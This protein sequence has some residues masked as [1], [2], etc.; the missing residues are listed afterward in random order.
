MALPV[1]L[2][3]HHPLQRWLA[4]AV[5]ALLCA[6]LGILL[7]S[8]APWLGFVRTL[9]NVFYDSLYRLR[10]AQNMA[11][12][13][14]VIVAVDDKSIDAVDKDRKIGWPWPRKY[15]GEMVSYL[16]AA[17]AKVIAI[18]LLFD[19][20]SVYNNATNHDDRDFAEA[21]DA[22]AATTPTVLA[23]YLW[24]DGT[25][26]QPVPPV[27]KKITGMATISEE[28][29]IRSYQ[30][31]VHGRASLALE[32]M[33][34]LGAPVPEW[35]SSQTPFLLRYY[36]PHAKGDQPATFKYVRAAN[37]L[38]AAEGSENAGISPEMF[39]GK[40][41]FIATIT[42]GTF[43]L[44]ASPLSP[45]FPGVEVHATAAAN[46]LMNQRVTPV[47]AGMR[48]LLLIF[49]CFTAAAGM[50]VP[51]RIPFKVLGGLSGIIIVL[52]AT[53]ALFLSPD[54]RWLPPAAAL[55]AATASAFTALIWT[56][57]TELRQR[58][59]L[60]K[61]ISHYVSKSVADE[62][63]RDPR[64][65]SLSGERREM[66]VMFTDLVNFTTLSEKLDEHRLPDMLNFY[67]QEMSGVIL[68]QNGTLDKYI[69]DSIMSFWNAPLNQTDH[70]R[71][72]CHAALEILSREK[73]IE[74]QLIAIANGPVKSRM[75]INSGPMIVGNMGSTYRF[76]YTVLG[77]SVNFASRLESANKMYG[78]RILLSGTTANLVRDE[79]IV[80]KVDLL[81][82]KGKLK[83]ME[84]YELMGHATAEPS[85]A[86]LISRYENALAL[87]QKRQ[88]NQAWELLLAIAQDFP[89]DGPTATLLARV[90]HL[91]D[92]PPPDDWD[93]VYVA[94]EK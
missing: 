65:L 68:A 54:I 44:K 53:A 24:P 10:P 15:W 22:V 26:S 29:I 16:D 2:P 11:N 57:L 14:I 71:R 70:A 73:A 36:G 9:D 89:Q 72:A 60:L 88:L 90:L 64:K 8:P 93:G 61:A 55:I 83:P 58:R 52:G 35:A 77:D 81:R 86:Q 19:R 7:W 51:A 49:A 37:L 23:T 84:I 12:S 31:V 91:R 62:L 21:I 13:P 4:S 6:G 17:G 34:R 59:F 41:V 47:H 78:T 45:R 74:D 33:K 39:K 56:Y 1:R 67:L 28:D 40:I 66:T 18:D 82:V 76:D 69:G 32:A 80:R 92:H 27:E 48:V 25:V 87:Y 50:V 75:G 79:F 5:I 63:A 43:D 42:A 38:S 85:Q 20:S 46:M 94:Q 30:P 3:T